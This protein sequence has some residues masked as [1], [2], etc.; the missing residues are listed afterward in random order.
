MAMVTVA[1]ARSATRH[2]TGRGAAGRPS[3]VMAAR[4][5]GPT[6]PFTVCRQRAALIERATGI[7]D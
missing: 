4:P 3:G 5:G 6:Q 2:H 1:P 7:V